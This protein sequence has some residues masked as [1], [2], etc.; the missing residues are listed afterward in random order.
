MEKTDISYSLKNVPLPSKNAYI[1]ALVPKVTSFIQRLRWRA[2]FFIQN[3]KRKRLT[4]NDTES[5]SEEE[6]ESSKETFGFNTSKSA[7]PIPALSNFENDLYNTIS[8]LKFNNQKKPFQIQLQKDVDT[9]NKSTK[10]FTL[11]DKTNN[12]YTVSAQTYKQLL[13]NNITAHYK[14][15]HDNTE[16]KINKEAKHI[17]EKLEIS[18]RVQ[19]IPKKEAFVTIKDHKVNFKNNT[20]CRLINPT[21]SEI[22]KISKQKLQAITRELKIKLNLNQWIN[23]SD[24]LEWFKSLKNKRLLSFLTFDVVE[25]YPSIS[26]SLF[27]DAL[28]FAATHVHIT[29]FDREIFMNA[30]A[31]ILYSRGETWIKRSGLFDTTMGAYDGAET[32]EIIGLFMLNKLKEK[33]P[34]LNIGLYRDDGLAAH[35]RIPGPEL[36]R[37]R[38]GIEKLFKDHGLSITIE[39]GLKQVDFLDI[40]LNLQTEKYKPYKKPNNSLSYI[41]IDSNHPPN[42]TKSIPKIINQRLNN[43]SCTKDDFDHAKPEYEE[44]LRQSGYK[45]NSKLTFCNTPENKK[46]K[47]RKR[48]ITWFNPPFAANLST[49]I[50]RKFINLIEKHFPKKN[51]LSKIINKHTV[52]ISYSCMPNMRAI[53]LKHNNKLLQ[54]NDKPNKSGCNCRKQACPLQENC[55]AENLVYEAALR[56]D[57][58]TVKYYGSTCTTFK[59]RWRNHTASFRNANKANDTTLAAYVWENGLQGSPNV[60]WRIVG[61]RKPVAPNGECGVCLLEKTTIMKNNGPGTLNVRGEIFRR[62][63]HRDK[64]S[65]HRC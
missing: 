15:D 26:E 42:I 29:D 1:N 10:A 28:D 12:V 2:H 30:R 8:N 17:C 25:F 51:P 58:K 44:A 9:I 50:G 48:K 55:L 20:K 57:G 27:I 22:G 43:L 5:D 46:K 32:C 19:R 13:D 11:A 40:N 52:K 45:E 23:T 16:A 6:N 60:T 63:P 7:P 34:D 35:R 31:S 24:V 59:T 39:T 61:Q 53:I 65:I 64:N 56:H 54:D 36:D 18:D 62:C 41:N 3:R 38:K 37:M 47:Q 21:K 33:Y 49:D 4:N 14:K